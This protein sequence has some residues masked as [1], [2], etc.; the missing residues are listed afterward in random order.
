MREKPTLVA[1]AYPPKPIQGYFHPNS[2]CTRV[3]V[4]NAVAV[5]PD[6]KALLAE[7]SGRGRHMVYFIPLTSPAVIAEAKAA[8]VI[9]LPQVERPCTPQAFIS[10]SAAP[11]EYCI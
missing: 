11:G 5:C 2:F 9:M 3:A 7:A 4:M 6:G 8:E 1:I 10:T